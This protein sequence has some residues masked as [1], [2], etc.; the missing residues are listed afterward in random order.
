MQIIIRI[1]IPVLISLFLGWLL[2]GIAKD[3][4]KEIIKNLEKE[5]VVIHLPKAY[6]WVGFLD[7]FTFGT[8]MIFMAND[9]SGTAVTWVWILFCFFV[10]LGVFII[11][12]TK[13][14][15]IEI[16]RHKDYFIYRT[17]FCRVHKIQYAECASYEFKTNNLVLKTGKRTFYVDN[18]ATNFEFL[19]AMLS[20][21]KVKE[22]KR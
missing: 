21:H 8:F 22:I 4:G 7:V 11:A 17:A 18:K 5:H 2:S 15:K 19:M 20:Q 16:F 1:I 14:W 9:Q 10:L 12:E 3:N 13:I 6:M